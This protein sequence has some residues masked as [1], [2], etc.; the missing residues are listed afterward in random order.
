MVQASCISLGA[1][2]ENRYETPL[3]WCL[4]EYVAQPIL[5][6]LKHLKIASYDPSTV[7]DT[8]IQNSTLMQPLSSF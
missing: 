4:L 6:F 2:D 5:I 8:L 3:N 7:C 1:G